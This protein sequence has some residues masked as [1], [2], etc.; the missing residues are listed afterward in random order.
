MYKAND[1]QVAGGGTFGLH[2][3]LMDEDSAGKFQPRSIVMA[4]SYVE[5][6]PL[7]WLIEVDYNTLVFTFK[8]ICFKDPNMQ[9][10]NLPEGQGKTASLAS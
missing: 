8:D 1:F 5:G 3:L 9:V 7:K 4:P 6:G 10:P 2:H